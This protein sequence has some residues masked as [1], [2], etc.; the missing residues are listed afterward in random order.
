VRLFLIAA[1]FSLTC[2]A[3][4]PPAGTLVAAIQTASGNYLT[5]V[6]G[7]GLGGP[8][9]GP[10]AVA[11]H[12]DATVAGPWETFTVHWLDASYTR[13][14]LQTVDGHYLS[15]I[16]GGGQGG[17]DDSSSPIHTDARTIA[18]WETLTVNFLPNDQVTI[19]LPNGRFLTAVAGGGV[20]T[21]QSAP[22]HTDV[23][24]PGAWETF[25]LVKQG[26]VAR[27][28]APP[29][30]VPVPVPTPRPIEL[31][32]ADDAWLVTVTV[33]GGLTARFASYAVN[34]QG[35]GAS[36]TGRGNT[37]LLV[38]HDSLAAVETQIRIAQ[39]QAW[40]S[41]DMSCNDCAVTA[42]TL[43]QRQPGRRVVTHSVRWNLVGPDSPGNALALANA[44]RS[45]LPSVAAV[46]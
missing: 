1:M 34:S 28:A 45:A 35:N 26:T 37:R 14:S 6:G 4:Q 16:Q 13:F 46:H 5:A 12:T 15:A 44:V 9:Y 38:A 30:P 24:Q 32:G 39:S 33:S 18:E 11:L 41:R 17:P 3:A 2:G 43:S 19:N 10:A 36:S 27:D 31:P 8:D 29:A 40:V 25:T 21:P 42:I 22:L 7:G 20:G 23:V